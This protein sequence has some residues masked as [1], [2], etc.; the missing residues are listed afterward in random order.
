MEGILDSISEHCGPWPDFRRHHGRDVRTGSLSV[1]CLRNNFRR[2]RTRLCLGN[3]VAAHGRQ[4]VARNR[5]QPVGDI[6]KE[7]HTYILGGVADFGGRSFCSHARRPPFRDDKMGQHYMD[8]SNIRLL[9]LGHTTAHRQTYRQH[10]SGVWRGTAVHG[11]R[12]NGLHVV[13]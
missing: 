5:R 6:H 7:R 4:I 10:L 3:D 13:R 12:L 9:Y 11:R 2:R 8:S 1:D